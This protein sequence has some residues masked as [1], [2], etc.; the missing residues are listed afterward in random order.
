MLVRLSSWSEALDRNPA[1]KLRLAEFTLLL[2]AEALSCSVIDQ[3]GCQPLEAAYEP[4]THIPSPSGRKLVF[5]SPSP[6]CKGSCDWLLNTLSV[7]RSA[8][9]E[10]NTFHKI[11]PGGVPG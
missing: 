6:R 1:L 9:L 11:L 2:Q 10:L 8:G 5:L 3:D 4:C 7:C